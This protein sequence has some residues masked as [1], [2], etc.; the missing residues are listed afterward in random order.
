MLAL[1]AFVLSAGL[2]TTAPSGGTTTTFLGLT[3]V[4]HGAPGGGVA[5][6]FN[7]TYTGAACYDYIGS[8]ALA[9]NG[10][11]Q[12]SLIGDDSGT[13]FI[14]IDLGGLYSSVGGLMNY[15]P[16]GETSIA[17][18]AADGTTVLE[19]Y[20]LVIDAPISTPGATDAGAYRGIERAAADIR[21]F[22]L[23]ESYIVMH[24]ITLAGAAVPEPTA[25]LLA[26]P[27]LVGFALLRRR[28]Y[29]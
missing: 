2:I 22:Q 15:A 3:S 21:Y 8:F 9:T 12:I 11:W 6:G 14:T 16:G 29:M 25:W 10:T 17:A 24:N 4:C 23:G 27:A 5:T 20:N 13:T 28:R 18:L 26:F 1:S 7:I 19:S